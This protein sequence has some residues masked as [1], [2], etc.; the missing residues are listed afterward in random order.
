MRHT[1]LRVLHPLLTK[2]QLRNIPYKRPQLAYALES[3]LGNSRIRDVSPTTKRLVER[4]LSVDW[5]VQYRKS[6]DNDPGRASPTSESSSTLLSP[7]VVET[8]S[9]AAAA[10]LHR[11]PSA[12]A[13]ALKSSRSVENLTSRIG[14]VLRIPTDDIR[15]MSNGSVASLPSAAAAIPPVPPLPSS[16]WKVR[17][18]SSEALNGGHRHQYSD[19]ETIPH[20]HYQLSAYPQSP[21]LPDPPLSPALS[22]GAVGKI[23]TRRPPPPAPKKRRQ[24]PA[25]PSHGNNV[26]MTTI[27]SSSSPLAKNAV[28]LR[29]SIS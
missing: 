6:R 25:V 2:T 14:H 21:L 8:V 26:I 4:C 9:T 11:S 15:R 17:N 22:E 29:S 18:G 28:E 19:P 5:C 27:R 23:K 10:H 12:K 24:P 1:Y 7:T 13:R 3:L 16:K 20:K